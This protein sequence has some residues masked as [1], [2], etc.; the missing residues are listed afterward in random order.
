MRRV[1]AAIALALA[2]GCDAG[3]PTPPSLVL[4]SVDR[5]AADRLGCFGGESESGLSICALGDGGTLFAWAV[6]PGRGEASGVA[7]LLTGLSESE[8]GVHD[9]GRSFLA[10]HHRTL[11]EDLVA[12]GYA[13]AAF[14]VGPRVNRSRRLDQGFDRYEDR[15]A[16]PGSRPADDQSDLVAAVRGWIADAPPPWFVWVHVDAEVELHVLDRLVSRLSATL[17]EDRD[18]RAGVL[19]TAMR[20]EASRSEAAGDRIEWRTHRV[21]LIWR[22]PGGPSA[23]AASVSRV[24]AGLVDVAPTLRG[25]AGLRAGAA[26]HADTARPD[27][28]EGPSAALRRGPEPS[29]TRAATPIEPGRDLTRLAFAPPPIEGEAEDRYLLLESATPDGE[30]GLASSRH[31][32]AR[33]TSPLDGTGQPVPTPALRA[34]DARFA[35][36]PGDAAGPSGDLAAYEPGPWRRDLLDARSPVPRLELQLARALDRRARVARTATGGNE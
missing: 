13:T 22:P 25:A 8:H 1:G 10:D 35:T 24:L 11:A 26:T 30:V 3:E 6:S 18:P 15:L 2:L 16:P 4:L 36:L 31:L 21:P 9:D 5:L 32:Y 17:D 28:V 23:R 34:L 29:R 7:T 20:G 14:V 33:G 27:R 19:F 12:A